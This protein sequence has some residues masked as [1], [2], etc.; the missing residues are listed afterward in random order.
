MSF[1]GAAGAVGFVAGLILGGLLTATLG[2]VSLNLMDE[3][4][5]ALISPPK[6]SDG[7]SA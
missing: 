2:W 6:Q 4:W 7:S 5:P 1:Y 3:F